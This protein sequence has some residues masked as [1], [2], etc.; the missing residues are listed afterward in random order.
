MRNFFRGAVCAAAL[1]GCGPERDALLVDTTPGE[2]LD[3][4]ILIDQD[5]TPDEAAALGLSAV[6]FDKDLG[7]GL[8]R[9]TDGRSVSEVQQALFDRLPG[10]RVEPNVVRRI[11]SNDPQFPRQWNLKMLGVEQCWDTTRGAGI[12]VAVVDTGVHPFGQDTPVN[13]LPGIDLVDGD[14]DADDPHGHG[15]HVAGTIAQATDNGVGVAGMAPDVNILPVR[16]INENGGGS[17]FAIARGIIWAVQAGADV[18]NLSIGSDNG[19]GAEMQAIEYALSQG[20]V[21]VAAAGN[22][23]RDQLSFPA[24]Y[25]G[26]IAVGAVD[27]LGEVTE[28]SNYGFGLDVVAPGGLVARDD[29]N[30]N[31]PDGILQETV[32]ADGQTGFAFLQGTSMAAPH[33]SAT[34][35]LLLAAGARPAEIETLLKGTARDV[36]EPGFDDRSGFGLIDPVA[37]LAAIPQPNAPAPPPADPQQPDPQTDPQ[38]PADPQPTPTPSAGISNIDIDR[39]G[40]ILV[41]RWDTDVPATSQAQFL[42]YGLIGEESL[43]TDHELQISVDFWETYFV[44]LHSTDANGNTMTSGLEVVFPFE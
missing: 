10:A 2:T 37:A 4:E 18:I 41:M 24:A 32:N 39:F 42:G 15:T 17:S 35:A 16:V 33:V 30:D 31:S 9:V 14:S 3:G 20:V 44:F 23:G 1:V 8:Y 22:D 34:A 29:D 26:V 36:G 6:E 43:T 25:A 11:L 21:V 12:T 19:A 5:L 38:Q 13:L 27:A 28:Y 40:S 7:F